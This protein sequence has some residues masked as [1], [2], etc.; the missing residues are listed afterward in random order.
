MRWWV[1]WAAV[2]TFTPLCARADAGE[3]L[4]GAGGVVQLPLEGGVVAS[5]DVGLSDVWA[6]QAQLEGRWG[7]SAAGVALLGVVAAWDV[8]SWVPELSLAAGA[9]LDEE[10]HPAVAARLG[11]R[12]YLS[13]NWSV[14]LAAGAVAWPEKIAPTIWLELWRTM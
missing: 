5:A 7:A 10:L 14:T 9:R 12:R 11:V 1:F 8:F 6:A 2:A 4:V 13:P 3:W